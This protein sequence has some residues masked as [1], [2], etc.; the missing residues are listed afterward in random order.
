VVSLAWDAIKIFLRP[1][2][3]WKKEQDELV[4][5]ITSNNLGTYITS[6]ELLLP[7]KRLRIIFLFLLARIFITIK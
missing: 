3:H 4:Q 7:P 5:S 6:Q 2:E 1:R